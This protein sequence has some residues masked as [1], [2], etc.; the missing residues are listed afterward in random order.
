MNYNKSCS[1]CISFE[2]DGIT[3][4]KCVLPNYTTYNQR[5]EF[6]PDLGLYC[7]NT[8]IPCEY[9]CEDEGCKDLV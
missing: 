1:T 4:G 3:I 2:Y 6:K 5:C 9:Y 8:K 7:C